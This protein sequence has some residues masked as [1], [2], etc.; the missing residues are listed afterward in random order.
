MKKRLNGILTLLLVFAVQLTFAQNFQITGMV[1]DADG[2]PLPGVNVIVR[3]TNTGTT[4]DFDGNYTVNATQG[5]VLVYSFVGYVTQ[6]VTVG[7]QS[8]INV[9]LQ[10]DAAQL[11]EVIVLGYSTRGVEEVTGSS[12]QIGGEDIAEIPLVSVDQA[13]QGKVAGLQVTT[14][15]GTPGSAQDIRIRGQSSL[16]AG[17]EPLYVID[18]VPV[19]NNNNSG[20]ANASSFNPLA[21]INSQ[22]IASVTVLKD[23]SAT[24]AYGARGSNGVIVV[25]TKRGKSGDTQ[26]NFTSQVGVQ[27]DAYNK[28]D[29]LTG[30]QRLELLAE[31]LVASYGANGTIA[32]QGY[33]IGNA[34][35]RGVELGRL[36]AGTQNYDGTEYDWTGKIK[37]EDALMQNLT[38]SATG[39]DELG[40]FY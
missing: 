3:G 30:A 22:D 37:N 26:F 20:N 21:A 23:A 4:T 40:S 16:T 32:D 25:T 12:V 13:L 8:V 34:I 19:T 36:P 24:A 29:V 31:S 5:Q 10:E 39:G 14:S 18:G 2:M 11:D 27:N 28:R 15:S 9:T 33:T 6:N 17:N 7:A 38:F 1:S 35:S